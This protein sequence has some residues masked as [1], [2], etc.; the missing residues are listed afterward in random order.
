MLAATLRRNTCHCTFQNLQKCLLH[1]FTGNIAGYG[2]ILRFS[3]DLINL[4]N[5]DNSVLCTFN[6]IICCLNDLEKNILNILSYIS[7]FCQCSSIC[8]SK[9]YIQKSGKCL[10]QQSFT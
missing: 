7:G 9:R 4:I 5:I 10:S 3:C 8:N 6:I 1:A 2:W